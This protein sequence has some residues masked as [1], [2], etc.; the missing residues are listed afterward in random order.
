MHTIKG[1]GSMFGFDDLAA[2]THEIETVFDQVRN[3]SVPVT[4]ELIDLTLS[5]RDHIR[6]MLDSSGDILRDEKTKG[7]AIIVSFRQ[8]M[9]SK[10]ICADEDEQSKPSLSKDRFASNEGEQI[11]YRI[12]FRPPADILERGIN[13]IYLLDDLRQL[14]DCRV[15]AQVSDI[16][17]LEYLDMEI[18]Y[19][20]WDII[21][22]TKK[23]IDAIKDMYFIFIEDESKIRIDII[24]GEN[25]L[26][27]ESRHKKLGDILV[28]RGDLPQEELQ[29]ILKAQKRVGEMLV[30]AGVSEPEQIESALI[31]QQHVKEIHRKKT[32]VRYGCQ[33]PRAFGKTG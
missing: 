23:G 31:E 20:Y 22:T 6:T 12:R 29:K 24:G 10:N 19:T 21:L 33:H 26:D 4:K 7:A 32:V 1:S 9:P 27:T 30:E 18:C 8:Y 5:A 3:G 16:P 13:P 15:V 14:G 17:Y 28:E 25:N 11:T 2:F